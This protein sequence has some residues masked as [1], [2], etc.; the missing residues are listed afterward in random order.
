MHVTLTLRHSI[1]TLC[2]AIWTLLPPI[3]TIRWCLGFARSLRLAE[4]PSLGDE[5]ATSTHPARTGPI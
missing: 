2:K 5:L 1:A 3:R 4:K